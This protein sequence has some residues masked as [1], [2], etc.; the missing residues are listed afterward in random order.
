M[1]RQRRDE[2]V[3]ERRTVLRVLSDLVGGGVDEDAVLVLPDLS[4]EMRAWSGPDTD[5]SSGLP[6]RARVHPQFA[7]FEAQRMAR[8]RQGASRR[9]SVSVFGQVAYGSPGFDQFNDS[10]HEYW[11][12][13]VRVQWSPWNWN[14]REREIQELAVQRR[15]IDTHEERFADV[16]LRALERP[17]GTMEHMREALAY[18]D[19]IV[20]LREEATE[21]AE[22][23]LDE[24]AIP[25]S[26]YARVRA[27]LQTAR[28]ARLR[29]R[30]ELA[31]ARAQYLITLGVE[32]R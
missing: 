27:D 23:R 14:R 1:A 30:I 12:A 17:L 3:H 2:L 22:A 15:I 25:A 31:R 9:P 7:A 18:D 24:Q 4:E 5:S 21:Y 28:I 11:R 16:M 19:E 32:L 6:G 8:E 29:H 10:L 20:A 13:G 26:V